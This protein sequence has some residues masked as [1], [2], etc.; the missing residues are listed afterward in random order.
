M[1]AATTIK[2]II[3]FVIGE[4]DGG[5]PRKP[6]MEI[7]WDKQPE[8]NNT[9]YYEIWRDGKATALN[10]DNILENNSLTNES[11]NSYDYFGSIK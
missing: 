8:E 1:S 3:N 11:F 6:Y 5:S 10:T 9:D 7:K 2:P 4:C